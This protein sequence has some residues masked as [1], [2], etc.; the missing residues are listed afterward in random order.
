MDEW[1]NLCKRLNTILV[2]QYKSGIQTMWPKEVQDLLILLKLVHSKASK[3]EMS[4]KAF[5][6]A[7]DNLI[8]FRKVRLSIKIT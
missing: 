2:Q 4:V 5:N 3:N 7:I 1:P 8:V 6:K